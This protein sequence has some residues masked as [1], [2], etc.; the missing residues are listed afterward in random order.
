MTACLFWFYQLVHN[1][2]NNF[3]CLFYLQENDIDAIFNEILQKWES[4]RP[5]VEEV[6]K[7]YE[8]VDTKLAKLLESKSITAT[9][10]RHQHTAEEQRIREQILAQYSQVELDECEDDDDVGGGSGGG[11]G[12]GGGNG[13]SGGTA[14]S[15]PIMTKNTNALDVAQLTKERREQAKLDSKAKKDKDKEDR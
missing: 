3:C 5:K 8:D 14:S 2:I 4:S 12:G 1:K 15:D 11:S 7:V 6:K 10:Q 9:V 13:G